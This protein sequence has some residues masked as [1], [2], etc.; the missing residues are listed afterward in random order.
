MPGGRS[1]TAA[2]V[3]V[4]PA[5]LTAFLA[6]RSGGYFP[7]ATAL[8]AL[9]LA[10]V[11]LLRIVLARRPFEGLSTASTVAIG[12]LALFGAWILASAAWSGSSARALIE[13]DRVVLYLLVL[14]LAASLPS[15]PRTLDRLL[16]GLAATMT[17]LCVVGLITRVL[18]DLWPL[19]PA[20][21][22]ERLSFPIG[23]WNALGLMAATAIVLCFHFASNGRDP[24]VVRVLGAAALPPLAATLLFTFSRAPLALTVLALVAY[25]A[26]AR[27]RSLISGLLATAPTTAVAVTAA[28]GADALARGG[29]PRF[30]ERLP[31]TTPEAIAQGR[32]LAVTILL[33]VAAA[34]A[35][36]ALLL[37]LDPRLE[38]LRL[39]RRTGGYAVA[40]AALIAVAAI[41]LSFGTS[42]PDRVRTL[43]ERGGDDPVHQ[44]GDRRD[45]LTNPGLARLDLWEVAIDAYRAAPLRGQGAGTYELLYAKNRPSSRVSY[46]AHSLYLE[47][48]AEL[49]IIG[50][51]LVGGALAA[52]LVGV[53]ARTRG[54]NRATYAAVLVATLA[55]VLNAGVDWFWELPAVTAWTLAAG[56][57][58]VS[59]RPRRDGDPRPWAMPK[60]VVA[61]L[62][63]VGL[64]AAPALV[65]VSQARLSESVAAYEEGDCGRAIDRALASISALESRPEPYEILAYCDLQARLAPLAVQMMQRAVDRDPGSWDLRYGL[66]LVRASA[67]LDPRPAARA[68]LVRNPNSPQAQEAA[69]RFRR[70]RD[71]MSWRAAARDLGVPADATRRQDP[72]ALLR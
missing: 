14:L 57:L 44:T 24:K 45:R 9:F 69:A 21:Q 11:L 49:G 68:A 58:A 61:A 41:A 13:F 35:L 71:P 30:G 31:P 29:A 59:A 37:W 43:A 67:G 18:P 66:A 62:A 3:L 28:Y 10:V 22:N 51:L 34:V 4:V 60:R 48:L 32:S 63:C 12:A 42:I 25:A 36:R 46:D 55:W 1:L 64:A 16:W 53:A 17:G 39:P 6:V 27:P 15:T 19:P 54:R 70:A 2:A 5:A 20:I 8:S 33:C 65:A 38:R 23:Y 50:L 56:G 26:L 40:G 52:L 7:G 47:T 72:P